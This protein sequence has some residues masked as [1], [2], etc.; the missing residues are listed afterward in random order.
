MQLNATHLLPTSPEKI[1]ALLM[2]TDTLA[3]IVPGI[4]RLEDTGNNTFKS[5]LEIK[6]GPVSGAFTGNL[7]LED[8]NEPVSF[9]LK[10][11]Q[12]SKMGNADATIKI[13]MTEARENQTEVSFDG[14]A[15]ISGLLARMGQRVLGGVANTLTKQFFGNLEKEIG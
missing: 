14:D 13:N 12:N 11:Q 2:D 1:W 6:I 7:Q 9:T 5:I 10:V 4:T 8:I 15:K 3:K